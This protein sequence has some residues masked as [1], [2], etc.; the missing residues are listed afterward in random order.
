MNEAV[1]LG[2]PSARHRAWTAACLFLV[3]LVVLSAF[4]CQN[5]LDKVITAKISGVT[6][7]ALAAL[8]V[9]VSTAAGSSADLPGLSPAFD[10]TETGYSA[11]ADSL[12]TGPT[13]KK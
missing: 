4:A 5:P 11:T 1:G 10:A 13:F 8:N 2:S 6:D 3:F 9:R 7:T 12:V